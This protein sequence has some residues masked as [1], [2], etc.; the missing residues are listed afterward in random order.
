MDLYLRL[1]PEPTYHVKISTDCGSVENN[2][3]QI[4]QN[5]HIATQDRTAQA[6]KQQTSLS[7]R[8]EQKNE[9]WSPNYF[10][11][12]ENEEWISNSSLHSAVPAESTLRHSNSV[13]LFHTDKNKPDNK[14]FALNHIDYNSCKYT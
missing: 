7:Y 3:L 6:V 11:K 1:R 8:R 14:N 2:F 12:N 4:N 5:L 13:E 10:E 9:Y